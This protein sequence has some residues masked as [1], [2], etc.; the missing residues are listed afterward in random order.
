[1]G[2]SLGFTYLGD[3]DVGVYLT[4]VP[5]GLYAAYRFGDRLT[6]GGGALFSRVALS[7]DIEK[8]SSLVDATLAST[9]LQYFG[10]LEWRVNRVIALVVQL[11]ALGYVSVGGDTHAV[12]EPNDRTKVDVVYQGDLHG[13]YI[14]GEMLAASMGCVFSW[15]VLNVRL[16]LTA[17]DFFNLPWLNVPVPAP[18]FPELDVYARW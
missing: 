12:T 16:G 9:N 7:G 11:R 1:M 18:L 2:T 13:S 15:H 10:N 17:G 5:A 4:S 8:E 6:L 3:S 14:P